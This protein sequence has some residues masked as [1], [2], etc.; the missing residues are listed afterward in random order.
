MR[1]ALLMDR[2]GPREGVGPFEFPI[3]Q[4][5]LACQPV[6]RPSKHA[7]YRGRHQ[8]PT[9]VIKTVPENG[10]LEISYQLGTN[11]TDK[12]RRRAVLVIGFLH[13]ETTVSTG[14]VHRDRSSG[15][16]RL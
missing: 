10:T 14:R 1:C 15:S 4:V 13:M 8:A 3:T 16:A 12:G 6:I 7:N 5:M 9:G 11:H 2:I